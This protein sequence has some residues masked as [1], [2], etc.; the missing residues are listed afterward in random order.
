MVKKLGPKKRAAV[1]HIVYDGHSLEKTA[2]LLH[3]S[4]ETLYTWLEDESFL[5]CLENALKKKPYISNQILTSGLSDAAETLC[6]LSKN[7][8]SES[9]RFQ[10]SKEIISCMKAGKT[11]GDENKN[12]MGL[13]RDLKSAADSEKSE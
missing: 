5:C 12:I 1:K 11:D 4:V 3:V 10:A 2:C 9:V 6:F 8:E 13:I 7:A